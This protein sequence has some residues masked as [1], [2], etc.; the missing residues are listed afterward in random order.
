M[1]N[2]V[3]MDIQPQPRGVLFFL[4]PGFSFF[5]IQ[6]VSLQLIACNHAI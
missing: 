6:S 3:G 2:E 4:L 1:M 5:S